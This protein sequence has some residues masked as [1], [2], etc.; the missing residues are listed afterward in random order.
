MDFFK[1][2][3]KLT[4]INALAG[5]HLNDSRMSMKG[6]PAK[7]RVLTDEYLISKGIYQKVKPI[8]ILDEEFIKNVQKRKRIKTKAAEVEHAIRHHIEIELDDDPELQALFS[9]A[10]KIIFEEFKDNW[11]KIFEELEKLRKRI[12]EAGDEPTYGLRKKKEMPFFRMLRK[13]LDPNTGTQQEDSLYGE[14][15]EPEIP[16]DN[17]KDETI[18][19][20][21]DLTHQLF[22]TIER[23]IKMIGFWESV[24]ARNRLK[25]E[26]QNLLLSTS[27][28]DIPGIMKKRHML[29]S[30]IMELAEKNNDRILYAD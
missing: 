4:E 24:P 30:R 15:K 27:F 18:N 5:R 29:I 14:V 2:Y 13:E 12:I 20:V 28:I 25:G 21:V 23:E 17:G 7:L 22:I 19:I 16:Y 1:D 11:Q 8:S 10:L 9:E 3:Q 6:I 26:I